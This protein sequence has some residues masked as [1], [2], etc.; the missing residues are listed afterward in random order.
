MK[1]QVLEKLITDKAVDHFTR[2]FVSSHSAG[3]HCEGTVLQVISAVPL[4]FCVWWEVSGTGW[5]C[6]R[7]NAT[8]HSMDPVK[9]VLWQCRQEVVQYPGCSP[10]FIPYVCC[11]I[12]KLEQPLLW[13]TVCKWRQHCNSSST[14]EASSDAKDLFCLPHCW[15]W[16]LEDLGGTIMK[17]DNCLCKCSAVCMFHMSIWYTTVKLQNQEFILPPDSGTDINPI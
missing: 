9:N 17:V 6:C 13:E 15:Q 1:M 11:L 8:G 10:D 3:S 7:V 5:K 4:L 12:V 2:C 14:Y 16:T